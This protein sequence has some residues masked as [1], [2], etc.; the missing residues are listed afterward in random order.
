MEPYGTPERDYHRLTI[1]L[2]AAILLSGCMSYGG[3]RRAYL[4]KMEAYL[5]K[6]ARPVIVIPGFGNSRLYDS[7]E[8]KLVWGHPKNLVHTK[9]EDDLDLAI[10]P[11]ALSFAVDHLVPDGR[12]AGSPTPFNIALRLSNALIEYGRYVDGKKNPRAVGAVHTFAYDWRLSAV[13]N[14]RRLDAFIDAVRARHQPE[15]PRVDLV[16]H[17]AGGLVALAYLK[18][19]GNEPDASPEQIDAASR[20]AASKVASVTLIGVPQHGT[21]EAVRALARGDRLFLRALPPEMMA[22]FPSIPEMLPEDGVVFIDGRGDPL[23]HDVWDAST[24]EDL[25]FAIWNEGP[26]PERIA[27]FEH[28]MRRARAF[29]KALARPMPQGVRQTVIAGDCVPTA[30]YVLI[31]PDGSLAFYPSELRH[32]EKPL[33]RLMFEPGDGSVE[34]MSALSRNETGHVFCAGHF[35][36]AGDPNVHRIVIRELLEPDAE[37]TFAPHAPARMTG[38]ASME[39][40]NPR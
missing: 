9:Y 25:G 15:P 32:D 10:D 18:L 6:P 13:I 33:A 22:T 17:S 11:E 16:A 35:G 2:A 12:F 27:A 7:V 31:R 1:A 21:N 34:T 26:T 36:I 37:D 14:A 19:G 23:H 30:R 28:S 38:S 29:R 3:T 5:P 24:W 8:N 40:P 4:Q 39:T 20:L